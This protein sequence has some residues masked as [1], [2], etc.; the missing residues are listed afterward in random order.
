[1]ES[2]NLQWTKSSFSGSGGSCVE[3]AIQD[4]SFVIRNSNDL[5]QGVLFFTH[6]EVEAF[7][8]GCKAGEFDDLVRDCRTQ[9]LGR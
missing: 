1:M 7:V 5:E 4:G 9:D 2:R 3:L 8:E 6:E